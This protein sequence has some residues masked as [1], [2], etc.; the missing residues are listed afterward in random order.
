MATEALDTDALK[1]YSFQVFSK[2][3]GA[4]TAG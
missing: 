1:R 2:L 4:V 3:E